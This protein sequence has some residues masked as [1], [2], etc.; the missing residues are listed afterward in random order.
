[1]PHVATD[2]CPEH[3]RQMAALEARYYGESFITPAKEAW[4]CYR[5]YPYT[6]T[7][8]LHRE[9]VVGFVNLFPLKA[10]VFEALRSGQMNDHDLSAE[11]VEDLR[12]PVS[13][14]MDMF[15]SC[16]LVE[17]AY[18]PQGLTRRLL[19]A[20]VQPYL[21][22]VKQCRHVL[23]DTVTPAGAAFAKRYGFSRLG[24]SS[25]SSV[26]HMQSFVSLLAQ[27]GF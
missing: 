24:E 2:L 5:R 20:A 17:P 16:I 11:D 1:M 4:L 25:H 14:P 18:R 6:T 21:P 9:Q 3:F 10:A 8:A 15:L 22:H 12:A 13:L 7:A 19:Q 23:V 26:L 27:L